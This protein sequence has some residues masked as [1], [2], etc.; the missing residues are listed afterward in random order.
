MK[1]IGTEQTYNGFLKIETVFIQTSTGENIKREVMKR[2]SNGNSDD[3]VAALVYNKANNNYIFTKQFR[4]GLM[5]ESSQHLV[6]AVAGTLK[7]GED[8]A[9]CIE[10]EILEE[11]G[12]K[13]ESL[14]YIGS[15]FVSAGGCTEKLLLFYA[16]VE[17]K[18][19]QGG[20]LEEEHEEIEIVEMTLDQLKEYP[21]MDMKTELLISKCIK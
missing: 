1:I 2:S 7:H 17:H 3:S 8:P 13:V 14:K 5:H 10:R 12:Y 20:G 16:E 11:I 4:V 9:E 6:E 21:F 18:I 19:E 15:Y